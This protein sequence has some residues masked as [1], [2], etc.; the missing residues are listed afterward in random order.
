MINKLKLLG[1]YV[2]ENE[3]DVNSLGLNLDLVEA[4]VVVLNFSLDDKNCVFLEFDTIEFDQTK[5]TKIMYKNAKG[6]TKSPFP[7]YNAFYDK[8]EI[9]CKKNI[10]KSF[11][12]FVATMEN[13]SLINSDLEPIVNYLKIGEN[14]AI[15]K[16]G[17]YDNIYSDKS[18]LF[19]LKINGSFIGESA[20]Y[21]KII[22]NYVSSKDEVF[23]TKYN[24]KSIGSNVKCYTCGKISD[25]LYGFCD[26]F[27]FYSA[28]ET[29]YI[30]GGF[31]KEKTWK[32]FPVCP[33]CAKYLRLG[34]EKLNKNLNRY[35]YGNKYFLIPTPILDKGT[36]YTILQNIEEDFKD[37]S[38]NREQESNQQLRNEMEEDIFE[39]FARQENQATFT[40]FFYAASNSEFKILQEAEDILP[41][42]FK[43]II[44]T[45]KEVERFNEFKDLKGLYKKGENHDL[46]FN[47]GIVKT[48]FPSN[49]NNDFL[50]ITTK[51]L[52]GQKIS[53]SFI[54][55]QVSDHL[56]KGFRSEKL[57]HDIEKAMIFLKF[58]YELNLIEQTK[59]KM[60]FKMEN[61]Y[62]DYFQLHPEFY[63]ADWKKTVFLIGV[64]AQHVMDIQWQE[65]NAT[66]FRS[67]LNGL[68]LDHRAIKRLLPESIE[69]LEQYKS[70][71]Y[72]DLEEVIA[73]LMESGEPQLKQQ[74]VDEISFYFAMGMN[75]NKQFKS[76]KETEGDNN[77]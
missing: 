71:Y 40:F 64:L 65:R 1:E 41:S 8:D 26:T 66:P 77:E 7:T 45:K 48:F 60:E 30:A 19:T 62:E 74:S 21:K 43:K 59:N 13:N 57:Y 68:K 75:L 12:K 36:F 49:F 4:N 52:K 16:D 70:N 32:N 54:L 47:F 33:E 61:K 25:K 44:N 55:H 39:T 67:R 38:L 56:A 27:K 10:D 63:D 24:T 53:K 46:A 37:L 28:N 14:E 9:R 58:L 72:R 42:R 17:I 22:E 6:Q 20:L 29:A 50:D 51:I 2:H 76:K 35:F 23:F 18:N 73:K 34:Q 3:G 5:N 15:L 31:K 69:K 11:N